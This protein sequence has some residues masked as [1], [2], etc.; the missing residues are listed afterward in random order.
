MGKTFK[1]CG[2]KKDWRNKKTKKIKK[3]YPKRKRF[4]SERPSDDK[5]DWKNP[6]DF[7]GFNY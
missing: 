7:T 6:E 5:D 4:D 2:F 3:D 1:D